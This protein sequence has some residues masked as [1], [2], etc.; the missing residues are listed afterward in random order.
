M[1]DKTIVGQDATQIRMSVKQDAKQV[2]NLTL[3]PV[4]AVPYINDGL[5]YRRVIGAREGAQTQA[6]IMLDRKQVIHDGETSG[7]K[8]VS[9]IQDDRFAFDTTAKPRAGRTICRP[10]VIAVIE[11]IDTT[12]I[13]EHFETEVAIIAQGRRD[14]DKIVLINFI[15]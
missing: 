5:H 12:N 8:L 3:E 9:L 10:L 2:K 13:H 11:V 14:L 1:T 4:G 15:A 6:K 7:V